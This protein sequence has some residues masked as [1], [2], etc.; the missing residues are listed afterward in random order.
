MIASW[1]TM[2]VQSKE[3]K[4]TFQYT[5]IFS[6]IHSTYIYLHISIE[7]ETPRNR[8][9]RPCYFARYQGFAMEW[10]G[11]GHGWSW[12]QKIEAFC[13]EVVDDT[14][15]FPYVS[16]CFQLL[17]LFGVAKFG[18]GGPLVNLWAHS[19]NAQVLQVRKLQPA[20]MIIQSHWLEFMDP[21]AEKS[22]MITVTFC[23]GLPFGNQTWQW[24]IT[25]FIYTI[26]NIIIIYIYII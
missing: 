4:S 5:N 21:R 23:Y 8:S 20:S 12:S 7:F 10:N 11:D 2:G 6:Y 13:R 9:G 18:F 14:L 26:Y 22:W 15:S 17:I 19:E 24:T 25:P 16:L 1:A 3:R